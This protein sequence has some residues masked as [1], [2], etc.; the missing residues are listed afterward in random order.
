MV[1][2]WGHSIK[3]RELYVA[4]PFG[5]AMEVFSGFMNGMVV[6]RKFKFHWRFEKEK[7][8]LI[9]CR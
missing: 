8:S 1:C 6:E 4:L 2:F 5:L 7:I 3:A 9:F